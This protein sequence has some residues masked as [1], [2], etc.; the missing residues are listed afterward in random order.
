MELDPHG[1]LVITGNILYLT[2]PDEV[3]R[4]LAGHR[5]EAP[6]PAA[7][8]MER[9][10]TDEIPPMAA[11]LL[12]DLGELGPYALTGLRGGVVPR[13]SI[14]AGGF[15]VIVAGSSFGCGSSRE[16]API[17]LKEAGVRLIVAPS[18]ERIFFENC[19][20]LG[21]PLVCTDLDVL[22]ELLACG[23]V[24]LARLLVGLDPVS[25]DVLLSGGLLSY[26][27]RRKLGEISA[28]PVATHKRPMTLA[29]KILACHM[30]TARGFVKP[31]D[32]GFARADIRFSYELFTPHIAKLLQTEDPGEHSLADLSSI[33]LFADHLALLENDQADA[34]RTAQERFASQHRLRLHGQTASGRVEGIC[35]SLI[36]ERYARPG[37]LVV[38]TDSHTCTAGA[39]GALGFGVGMTE[40]A[41]AFATGAVRVK[42]PPTIRIDFSGRVRPPLTAKD[43][44][45]YLLA[46]PF[47]RDGKAIGRVLEYGGPGLQDWPVDELAVLT[48]MAVE[49]GAFTGVV[50]PTENVLKWLVK[51]RGGGL[52]VD[53][54]PASDV[55]AEYE[56]R[57]SVDLSAVPL[58][59]AEPFDPRNGVPLSECHS[60]VEIDIAYVGSCTSGRLPDLL[61]CADVLRGRR[62]H[63]RV[64]LY[65]QASSLE[66]G[67]RA[68]ELGLVDV[69]EAAG[70]AFLPPGCGACCGLGPGTSTDASQVTIS[71]TNRNYPGRMGKGQAYLASPAVV[72]ASALAGR[73]SAP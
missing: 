1:D 52:D 3:A 49:A 44:M 29:E 7:R 31:G 68:R 42:V 40:M 41:N 55:N 57:F 56:N 24:P 61:A 45:L 27:R 50:P 28:P 62:V 43:V 14:I 37:Q 4:Q 32:S 30:E 17:A 65:V 48:N 18:V 54:V 12:A 72:A 71:S 13:D 16:H 20:N 34:L 60:A 19:V 47:V 36:L 10:S 2:T 46:L 22:T 9:I 39:V 11:G 51:R 67:R 21:G 64:R 63:P 38:G 73:I 26:G 23:S 5:L 15:Q 66:V 33:L 70:A 59:I 35:H 58:M 69:F 53:F 6:P 8:L 25:A